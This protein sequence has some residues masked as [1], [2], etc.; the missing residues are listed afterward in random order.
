MKFRVLC[1]LLFVSARYLFAEKGGSLAECRGKAFVDTKVRS[2]GYQLSCRAAT[3]MG[4]HTIN[5]HGQTCHNELQ[6]Q[7]RGNKET[8]RSRRHL[9]FSVFRCPW[10][11][12]VHKKSFILTWMD[13]IFISRALHWGICH[14][15]TEQTNGWGG[16][17]TTQLSIHPVI[18]CGWNGVLL[19]NRRRIQDL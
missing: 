17:R 18:V 3:V 12:L 13:Y 14:L 6:L 19:E 15:C 10:I 16:E 4:D 11:V 2:Y 5:F 1:V 8:F 9:R 7:Q